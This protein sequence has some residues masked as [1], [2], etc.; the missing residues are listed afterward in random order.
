MKLAVLLFAPLAVVVLAGQIAAQSPSK[1]PAT[2][3]EPVRETL[4][5]VEVLDNYRWLEGDN[6]NPERMGQVTPEVGAWTDL[7]NAHTRSVLDNL[8]GRKALEEQL[9]PLMPDGSGFVYQN[10]EDPK[11]PYSGRV[12]YHHMGTD[13]AADPILLRQYT[14]AENEKLATTWGP[15]GTLFVQT[16]L[17]APNGRIDA[18]PRGP[19][20]AATSERVA[21]VCASS[22]HRGSGG[23]TANRSAHSTT[24][25]PRRSPM[26]SSRPSS[27]SSAARSRR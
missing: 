4:H 21:P 25:M 26:T 18:L 7:Q 1:P 23:M 3:V 16:N 22:S 13:V 6:S 12:L 5:G 2:R 15:G 17:G 20:P 14:K 27:G 8:P 24:Q 10:L 9:R 19:V 11:D